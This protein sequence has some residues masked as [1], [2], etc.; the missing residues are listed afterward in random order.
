MNEGRDVNNLNPRMEEL[1]DRL[2]TLLSSFT[3]EFDVSGVEVIGA[4]ESVKLNV[5][6]DMY[7]LNVS[8][9]EDSE[10]SGE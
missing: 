10:D 6:M 3:E 4:L 2:E 1:Q 5:A 9:P 8:D 7:I